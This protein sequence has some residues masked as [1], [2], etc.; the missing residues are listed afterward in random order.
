MGLYTEAILLGMTAG[1]LAR[2]YM[3]RTDYR[4]YPSYPHG[5]IIHLSLGAIAA[6]LA[7]IALPALLEEEYTAVTFLVLCAQ[8]F[9]DIRNME[10]ET[11]MKLEENTLVPRGLDYIEGIAKVFESRNYLVMLVALVT[12]GATIWGGWTW[13]VLAGLVMILFSRF[14]MRGSYIRNIA[15]VEQGQLHFEKS[16]LYVDDIVIM[17]VGDPAAREKIL[18]EGIGL[19]LHPYDDDGRS[20]LNNLGQRQ[21]ML[22]DIS[23]LVGN[24]LEIGE[25]EWTPAARKNMETGALGIFLMPNEKDI[26]CVI[27]AAKRTPVL[28]SAVQKPLAN[29]I[30]R[31]AAD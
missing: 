19:M 26:A 7:A 23:M 13:G 20:V 14:L 8:Q 1:F 30:G 27:E 22:H 10:R 18:E 9:R 3:L 24:K 4:N 31:K 17:N 21:A 16:L 25:Q 28:E 11:L 12:S 29:T 15:K 5:Y 2:L 6:S